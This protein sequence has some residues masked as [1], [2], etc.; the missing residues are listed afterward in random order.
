MISEICFHFL[1]YAAVSFATLSV[2]AC[3]LIE[4]VF[5]WER[6]DGDLF[7]MKVRVDQG[8]GRVFLVEKWTPSKSS[9]AA[10]GLSSPSQK[11]ALIDK[12]YLSSCVVVSRKNWTCTGAGARDKEHISMADGELQYFYWG[13]T[14]V[15][16]KSWRLAL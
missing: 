16:R 11:F 4:D 5:V 14:R 13:E 10:V 6:S 12:S 15:Y 8:L 3:D 2:A 7:E 1:R 9:T